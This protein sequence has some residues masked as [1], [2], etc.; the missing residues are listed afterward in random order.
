M[1]SSGRPQTS[2]NSPFEWSNNNVRS[3]AATSMLAS[4]AAAIEIKS[5]AELGAQHA[6]EREH[7]AIEL[8]VETFVCQALLRDRDR[9]HDE[10]HHHHQAVPD[11]QTSPNRPRHQRSRPGTSAANISTDSVYGHRSIEPLP[12]SDATS[13]SP[14]ETPPTSR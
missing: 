2:S 11:C 7:Q 5:L 14:R 6:L 8:A 10:H 9:A 4:S 1:T 12:S 3:G 13:A